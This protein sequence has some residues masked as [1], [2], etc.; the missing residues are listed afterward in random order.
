MARKA[1]VDYDRE[2]DILYVYS[3]ESV[4]DSLEID[5]FVL[6]FSSENKIVGVEIFDASDILSGLS[7]M[8]ISKRMLSE[9]EDATISFK[10]SKDLFFVVLGLM[11]GVEL[12]KREIPIQVPAPAAA[13]SMR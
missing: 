4:K 8:K 6:D 1:K 7:L 10:Q 12:E 2:N 11:L 3:G 13:V 9:I 5:N